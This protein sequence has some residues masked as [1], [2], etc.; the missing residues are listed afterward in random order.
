V[1]QEN[2]RRF[3]CTKCDLSLPKHPA[4]RS[5]EYEEIEQL[6]R[7]R[8]IGP[9]TGFRSKMGRPFAAVLKLNDE[10]KLEFDFGNAPQEGESGEAVDFSALTP[11]GTCPKCK[12]RVFEQPMAYVCEK[13]VGPGRTCDFR[14]GKV[15][16][17]QPIE[18]EQMRKLLVEGKTDLLRGF[19]S[20]RTRRKFNAY[21]VRKPDGST[22]FEFEPRAAKGAGKGTA[23][24]G[25]AAPRS[26]ARK[27]AAPKAAEPEAAYTAKPAARAAK[28]PSKSAARKVASAKTAAKP[29]AKTAAKRG[30][31]ST[32]KR[33][34]KAAKTAGKSAGKTAGRK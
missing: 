6:L 19:I 12:A 30:T 23:T 10:F 15:I 20:N 9:L 26:A 24:E 14:S 28:A 1:V 5:F 27:A 25:A 31:T 17:Q 13:S 11:L 29:A 7:D 4:S 21:L 22:G 33:A 8:T 3:A 34:A 16:L 18:P 2:Y 32:A